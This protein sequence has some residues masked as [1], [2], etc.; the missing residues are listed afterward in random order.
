MV[1]ILIALWLISNFGIL[2]EELPYDNMLE[3]IMKAVY[4]RGNFTLHTY[5]WGFD[6]GIEI[7]I[8]SI[9]MPNKENLQKAP[10]CYFIYLY[11]WNV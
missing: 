7:G 1:W 11:N 6:Y 5:L 8:L 4:S 10:I 3:K 2:W 9:E